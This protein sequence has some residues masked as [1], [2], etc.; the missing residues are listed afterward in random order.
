MF[1]PPP[2]TVQDGQMVGF[3]QRHASIS[4]V[5]QR[6]P[7]QQNHINEW[8]KQ[9][10]L[11]QGSPTTANKH[12]NWMQDEAPSLQSQN[13]Y[14]EL[15]KFLLVKQPDVDLAAMVSSFCS[16]G[17]IT[18][19]DWIRDQM[20]AEVNRCSFLTWVTKQTQR[21]QMLGVFLSWK[22]SLMGKSHDPRNYGY[23]LF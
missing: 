1:H 3:I 6:H 18:N 12:L 5:F 15:F 20:C 14:H 19:C 22:Y 21:R 17:I 8:T 4:L 13:L 16:N 2:L 10:S 9:A 7:G 11:S 23:F